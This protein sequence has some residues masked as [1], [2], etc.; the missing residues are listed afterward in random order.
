MLSVSVVM[1]AYNEAEN[2]EACVAEALAFLRS[3]TSD[4]EL[5]FVSDG[6][7][8]DTADVARAF[9]AKQS[10][11]EVRVV[12]YTPNRGIGGALKAG[13]AE[14]SKDWVTLLPCDGQLPPDQLQNLFDVVERDASVDLVTCHYPERFQEAD[15]LYRKVLSRGLRGLMWL[16]TG[17][18]RKLDGVYLIRGSDLRRLRLRSDT[19]FLNLELPI[20]GIRGGLKP[21]ATT[22]NLR[23]RMAGE[24]KVANLSRMRRVFK[25]LAKLG[26]ELRTSRVE[27]LR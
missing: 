4:H 2:V 21:G 1:F 5:V 25:D 17:V 8:D 14:V 13:F 24:S 10:P 3:A 12:S 22:M 16:T 26:I 19:F 7:T 18:N 15:N 11:G 23:P 6:S 27:A 9:A 20:R